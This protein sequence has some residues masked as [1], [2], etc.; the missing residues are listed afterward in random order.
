MEKIIPERGDA[1]PWR[2]TNRVWTVMVRLTEL[3]RD[4]RI[5][6]API[7]D[8]YYKILRLI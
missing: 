6:G 4:A 3:R 1:D 7:R 2:A 8:T 5:Y